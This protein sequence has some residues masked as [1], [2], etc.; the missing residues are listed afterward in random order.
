[1]AKVWDDFLPLLR[2]HLSG[3]PDLTTKTFLAEVASDFF[4]RTYLWRDT[5]D[6][7]FV[8]PNQFEY[9]LD[10]D[11][12]VEDVISVV[13]DGQEL[14]RTDDRLLPH[15]EIGQK[16]VPTM[17]WVHADRT[18][19]VHPVPDLRTRL[20]VTAVLK[21]NRNGTGVEDWIYETWADALVDGTIAKLTA[22]PGKDWTDFGVAN[23]RLIMYE[24][25]ITRA[26]I[27][28]FR[29]VPLKVRQRPF[30]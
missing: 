21:P 5:I 10:A 20:R 19:R 14:H 24:K 11:A 17:Y 29:G 3:C 22:I 23:S 16:G 27:R 13:H 12:L 26:R 25:A 9:D 18:I 2:P 30:Y 15:T 7:I 8:A 28:D 1:M 6:S 4:T